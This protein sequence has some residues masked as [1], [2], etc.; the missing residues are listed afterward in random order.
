VEGH[1]NRLKTL[2]R[3]MYGR[4]GFELL[5]ARLLPCCSLAHSSCN[6]PESE[7]DIGKLTLAQVNATPLSSFQ[8]VSF[9][10]SCELRGELAPVM[11]PTLLAP[12]AALGA[13][14]LG[15]FNPFA[16]SPRS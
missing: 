13:L 15:W 6:K 1:I 8:N 4:A 11:V 9:R 5:R 7:P 3:Q 12:M 2:K 14:K 16:K 10:L